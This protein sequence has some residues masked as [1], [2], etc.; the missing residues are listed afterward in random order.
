MA[1]S[2][3]PQRSSQ[4]P[5]FARPN[6]NPHWIALSSDVQQKVVRLVA[7]LLRQYREKA[8]ETEIAQEVPSE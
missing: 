1:V 8:A 2:P 6:G 5:L 3:V 4:L 7:Q